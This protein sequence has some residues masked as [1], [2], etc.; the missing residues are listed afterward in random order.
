MPAA[1]AVPDKTAVGKVQKTGSVP[2]T[3]QAPMAKAMTVSVGLL[4]S[5][6]AAM[7]AAAIA[8]EMAVWTLRSP[9]RSER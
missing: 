1:A 9:R 7:P 3:P 8:S 4:V 6:D 2:N 5:V